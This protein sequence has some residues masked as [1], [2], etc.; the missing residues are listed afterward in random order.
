MFIITNEFFLEWVRIEFLNIEI[1]K[2][3]SVETTETP[4]DPPLSHTVKK[5]M[6]KCMVVHDI[7]SR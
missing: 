7:W 6:I 3:V 1:L 5:N 2:G 4:L